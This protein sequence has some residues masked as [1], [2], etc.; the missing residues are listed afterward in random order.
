MTTRTTPDGL[1]QTVRE[2]PSRKPGSE[3]N[4]AN[5]ALHAESSKEDV[6]KEQ[7]TFGRTPDGTVFTV[8]Q[9][10]D[11]VSQLLSPSQPKNL[12]DL[13][14]LAVLGFLILLLFFLPA[15]LRRPVFAV[16]FLFWRGCYNA[17]IGYLLHVQSHHCRLVTWAK[18]SKVFV[19][20]STGQNPHPKLYHMIKREL[21][22]KIPE[23][24]QFDE[25]PVEYN[26]WLVFRRVVDL[27]L[28]CD[29][30]SYCLFA[31]A[32]GGRPANEG[33]LLTL[34]RW[35]IGL[36]LVG[37]NLWVK[38]DAHRVVKDYAWYWGDF[39]YLI[40]QEL[41]FDGVFEMAPHPMYSVGYAGYYG[42]SLM[43]ASYSV[44][45]ISIVAH[46]AQF[47]FLF[48]V[49]N[50][51]I[52]KTYNP[53]P[54]R[55][56]L[57][58]SGADDSSSQEE[59]QQRYYPNDASVPRLASSLQPSPVHNLMGLRNLDLYRVTDTSVILL[60]IYTIALTALTPSTPLFQAMFILHAVAWRLWLTLGLGYV[61]HRQ[62]TRKRWTRHFVKF[63]ESTEEAW[64]Q[65]KG[66]Y[67]LSIT[68][69]YA[70][71]VAATYK[72]YALPADWAYGLVLL[73]HVLGLAMAALQIWTAF[74][75]Y[76]SLGEFGWFFGDFFFDQ[77]P[78]LTY[79]GIY[80]YLNNPERVI[81]LAGIWGAVLITSSPA[82]FFLALFSHVSTLAFI[83]LVERPHMQKLYGRDLRREAGLTK[84]IK[85]S[86]PPPLKQW[87]G[88]V[89]KVFAPTVDFVEDF[90]ES[91]RPK[92]AAGVGVFVRD[93]KTLFSQYPARLS[94]TRLAP[95][96]AGYDPKD[97]SLEISGTP[98][99]ALGK[100]ERMSGKEGE[101]A[102]SSTERRDDFK[103]LVFEYGAPVR[104]K[105]T[106]PLN[107]SKKDWVGLY[108]V[109]D[110]RSRD[111]TRVASAGR[112]VATNGGVYDS[113]TA[114]S[115]ILVSDVRVSGEGRQDGEEQ[116]Y[117]QGDMVFEGDK[118]WWTQG[119]F[120]F[121]YHHNGKHNVMAISLPFEIRIGRFDEDDVELDSSGLVRGAAERA[122]LRVVR[123]C[124]D[125]DPEI[126]PNTVDEAYGSLVERD[127]K[128]A[129]RVVFAV[130][131]MFGIEFAPEVVQA[132]GNVK[133]LAW[134]I[135]NAKKVLAPYSMSS[136]K[137]SS[138]PTTPKY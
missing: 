65:W 118:L 88:R 77:A 23:D 60:Q 55:K 27:I 105:W 91:A 56:H 11:M 75:I 20:P 93:T 57:P 66:M 28:M 72:I 9:T 79:S 78:K 70:S 100:P 35:A 38:L 113:T 96:L 95:D 132:D 129:K 130:H 62:S 119:V 89:D 1:A 25:A 54:A 43:A 5:G 2:R 114:D 8:P 92:F 98:S 63:G 97:Y 52:E 41:T 24:Y 4:N 90:I 22:T 80:R 102:Q 34:A 136:A 121:R 33:F 127:G 134:R 99:S 68:M 37:F 126:A 46:T 128:F 81:G 53:P 106:A 31:I 110:N 64:R 6:E 135:C 7:K 108:M 26:T 101:A 122:L 107:H 29:F 32:C 30:V 133:N 36:G 45:F 17:G 103:T 67:H 3:G 116:D 50:P 69:C 48:F 125:R 87:Q 94:I 115:G 73:K 49:E 40:D 123:N 19:D 59:D 58:A 21:E 10:H 51:H 131:Q 15:S 86:L 42:I 83:Q 61:L 44:L 12:S 111:A 47:A 76:D 85:R 117:L 82:I 120:E 71:F 84:S 74:S 39:F 138:T 13:V 14:V 112:W 16:I 18:R 104:V 109:A 124:F 137:G